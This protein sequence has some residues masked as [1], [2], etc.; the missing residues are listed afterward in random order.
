[1]GEGLGFRFLGSRSMQEVWGL[2]FR[3][4]GLG[5]RNTQEVWGVGVG[6]WG[7]GLWGFGGLV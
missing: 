6:G 4:C 1:M 2:V 3:V 7:L 5:F